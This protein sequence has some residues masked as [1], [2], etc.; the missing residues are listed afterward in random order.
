MGIK[1]IK[2]NFIVDVAAKLILEKSISEVTIKDIA[3][4]AGV[5]EAT[6][7]R[8]F[9]K[10]ENLLVK[11]A[12]KLLETVYEDLQLS[13]K[14]ENG[15]SRIEAFYNSYLKIFESH[16]EY[17]R[18]LSEFDIFI[19]DSKIDLDLDSY[20]DGVSRFKDIFYKAYNDG[21]IDGSVRKVED[22]ELFY[23]SSTHALIELCKKKAIVEDILVQDKAIDKSGEIKCLIGIILNNLKLRA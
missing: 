3:V 16:Q 20:E 7:Y 9:T 11:V 13:H 12:M 23:F 8:Y 17:F 2:L 21:L 1:E 6:V 18:F 14:D 19:H 5:G 22:L 15:F 4:K 10:K